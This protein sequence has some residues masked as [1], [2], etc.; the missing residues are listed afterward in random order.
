[1]IV[2]VKVPEVG[3]SITEG[4]LAE[5]H[6]G[7]GEVVQT[8]DPLFELETDKVTMTVSAEAAGRLTT[9][10]AAGTTVI[11]GQV[12]A[13]I[14]TD[15]AEEK[16]PDQPTKGPTEVVQ[17]NAQTT[18][19]EGDAATTSKPMSPGVRRMVTENELNAAAIP[20]TGRDGRLTREDVL[21]F[22]EE[23]ARMELRSHH[24]ISEQPARLMPGQPRGQPSQKTPEL[25]PQVPAQSTAPVE[26][27]TRSALS[28]LRKRLASRLVQVQQTSAIL[29][30]FNEV[31]MS[32]VISLRKEYRASFQEQHGVDLGFMSFFVRAVVEALKC[33]PQVNA[34]IDGDEVV[35]NHYYDIGVAVSSDAGLVVPV[36]R[37][38]DRLSMAE[39]EHKIAD[40]ARRARERTLN[41]N[42]LS[43]AVFTISNG[44]VF[45]S[46]LS[47][48]I[49]NPPQ[50]GILGMHTI[51]KRPVAVDDEIVIR[52][53]MYLALS[54]D[55][56]QVDGREAVTFLKQVVECIER[57][58]RMLLDVCG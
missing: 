1:M 23:R 29:T 14:D 11:V 53:M 15:A 8:D 43:G 24:R 46:L 57:P 13:S 44:G 18:G 45:G 56:R 37:E 41:L 20:A 28:P 51:K 32:H 47:T 38:A 42:D 16:R 30:T 27:Q 39:I 36:I 4:L 35:Q 21:H 10:V 17:S 9:N 19:P 5:W 3:E 49:L 34:Y 25:V 7:T 40:L 6:K 48:P 2:E 50:S 31:D 26:R 33:V 58:G 54:Y 12:I 52:P 55:H 22:L